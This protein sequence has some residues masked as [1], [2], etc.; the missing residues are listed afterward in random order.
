[1]RLRTVFISDIHLGFKGCSA[2]LLLEFLDRVEMDALLLVGA[3]I[4][5]W[6]R[7]VMSWRM[8]NT[9]TQ[10][11]CVEALQEALATHDKLEISTQI[12]APSSPARTGRTCWTQPTSRSAWTAS[13]AGSTTSSSSISGGA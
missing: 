9:M 3:I 10:D 13:A 1:M 8:S 11:F 12:R 7:K 2:D 5:V 6:S 4:D